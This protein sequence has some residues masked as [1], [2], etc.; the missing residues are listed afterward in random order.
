MRNPIR[1]YRCPE[2]AEL[3]R[4]LRNL[5]APAEGGKDTENEQIE[6]AEAEYGKAGSVQ[7]ITKKG[8]TRNVG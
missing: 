8:E 3:V 7:T 6:I 1:V 5:Q 4:V 2:N